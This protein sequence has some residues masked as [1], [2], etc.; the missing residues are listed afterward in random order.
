MVK[1][2]VDKGLSQPTREL[3]SNGVHYLS[4]EVIAKLRQLH[5]SGEPAMS[6]PC[7]PG[8]SWPELDADDLDFTRKVVRG[9]SDGSGT[10]PSQLLPV[11]PI[12]G[13]S[14]MLNVENVAVMINMMMMTMIK[15]MII[16]IL[17]IFE[18]VSGCGASYPDVNGPHLQ[19]GEHL[20]GRVDRLA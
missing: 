8:R 16:M 5:P 12:T 13:M 9:F 3:S 18:P 11:H 15:V 20:L 4:P 2:M 14:S 19:R 7:V 6:E 1:A 17:H 10:G